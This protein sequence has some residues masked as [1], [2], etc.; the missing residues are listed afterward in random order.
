[1]ARHTITEAELTAW[2][3]QETTWHQ[4]ACSHGNGS[5]KSLDWDG[6]NVFRVRDHGKTIFLGSDLAR[7]ITAYNEAQ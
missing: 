4:G 5:S 6:R 7:A 2:M 1:M 3:S